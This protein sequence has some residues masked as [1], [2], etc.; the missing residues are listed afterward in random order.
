MRTPTVLALAALAFAVPHAVEAQAPRV[1]HQPAAGRPYSAA[2]QVGDTYWFSG[3]IGGSAETRTLPQGER[4][5]AETHNIMQAF[6]ELFGELGLGWEDMVQA[7]IYLV[8]LDDYGPMNE[9]Y[10]SYFESDPPA[11]ETVVVSELVA[12]AQIEISF[13]AVQR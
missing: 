10:G 7:T 4:V 8:D 9:A 5:Q 3:K 6:E 2:I 13:V 12:G 11:R 1:A